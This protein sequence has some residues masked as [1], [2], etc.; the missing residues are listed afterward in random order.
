MPKTGKTA[1]GRSEDRVMRDERTGLPVRE[2]RLWVID[3]RSPEVR[4]KIAT[5][6]TALDADEEQEVLEWME[7]LRAQD[8][9]DWT[10]QE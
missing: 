4:Q 5:Q 7:S 2:V 6:V 10:P 3:D 8:D 9:K 1:V